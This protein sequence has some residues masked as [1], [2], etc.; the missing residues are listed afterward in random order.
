MFSSTVTVF[1][2]IH[3]SVQGCSKCS[4]EMTTVGIPYW[5]ESYSQRTWLGMRPAGDNACYH[6]SFYTEYERAVVHVYCSDRLA[7]VPRHRQRHTC[8]R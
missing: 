1:K 7:K 8:T 2:A 4:T 5:L 6:G 3:Y